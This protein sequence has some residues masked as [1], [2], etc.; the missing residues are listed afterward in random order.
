MFEVRDEEDEEIKQYTHDKNI[1]EILI[2]RANHISELEQKLWQLMLLPMQ[3]LKQMGILAHSM[4]PRY[5]NVMTVRNL[6]DKF[7]ANIHNY[8]TGVMS[9]FF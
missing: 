9:S 3:F 4:Q 7:Q 2:P 5:L 8:S 6:C 1:V